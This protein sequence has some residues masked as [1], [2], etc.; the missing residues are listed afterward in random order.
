MR[1]RP[2]LVILPLVVATFCGT[3]AAQAEL[4]PPVAA[5]LAAVKAG[6]YDSAVYEWTK[7]WASSDRVDSVRATFKAGFAR[8]TASG[9]LPKGWE[10]ARDVAIGK[11]IHRYYIV[12]LGSNDPVFLVLEAYQRPDGTWTVD[13]MAFNSNLTGLSPFDA[14]EF[15]E[16]RGE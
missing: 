15:F 1:C 9:N 8:I 6:S 14:S 7:A 16:S 5:G 3:L 12:I 10:L 11:T 2:L 4:P 13:R